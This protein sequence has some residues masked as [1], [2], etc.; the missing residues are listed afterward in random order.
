MSM[1]LFP[2]LSFAHRPLDVLVFDLVHLDA[3]AWYLHCSGRQFNVLAIR[4]EEILLRPLT[5]AIIR[6]LRGGRL[7]LGLQYCK[8]VIRDSKAKVV[9]TAND[10]SGTFFTLAQ[11][12]PHVKFVVFQSGHK[13]PSD[14]ESTHFLSVDGSEN[15]PVL[16]ATHG[17]MS[18]EVYGGFVA[19]TQVFGSLLNNMHHGRRAKP[20][21]D[22]GRR[23]ALISNYRDW[24]ASSAYK[25]K[26]LDPLGHFTSLVSHW[27]EA[28]N[29][30][31]EVILASKYGAS[32]NE[33]SFFRKNTKGDVILSKR[34][35]ITSSF[36]ALERADI[37]MAGSSTLGLEWASRGKVPTGLF[38]SIFQDASI[39]NYLELNPETAHFIFSEGTLSNVTAFMSQMDQV[40]GASKAAIENFAAEISDKILKWVPADEAVRQFDNLISPQGGW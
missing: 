31:F 16:L 30:Q 3:M 2:K 25:H 19:E 18:S 5:K 8:E 14:L 34:T 12:T 15:Y 21:P 20:N 6:K 1:G 26:Y 35:E 23:L 32:S 38:P 40:A 36:R 29:V 33:I 9:I 37:V 22:G 10:A 24:M 17:A 13:T 11:Q 28:N 39:E 7:S 4:K 27:C